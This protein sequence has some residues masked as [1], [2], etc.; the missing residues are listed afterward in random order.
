MFVIF[1]NKATKEIVSFRND[2]SFPKPMTAQYHFDRY[3]QD[4]NLDPNL[5]AYTESEWDSNLKLGASTHLYTE[6]TKH[7][8]ANP[9]Y[10]QP[11][12]D[13]EPTPTL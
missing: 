1:Y 5:F 6:S 2:T 4:G 10:V 3:C 8:E 12:L 13:L 11:E 7:I 9:N